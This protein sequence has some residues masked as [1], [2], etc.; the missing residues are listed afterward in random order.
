ME[1]ERFNPGKD[2]ILLFSTE[3]KEFSVY[4]S[5]E[6]SLPNRMAKN[7][8][9]FSEKHYGVFRKTLQWFLR[10]IMRSGKIEQGCLLKG[11]LD[12]IISIKRML[13]LQ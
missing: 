7:I 9:V 8:T 13:I 4:E 3:R 12:S 5:E 11:S 10:E 2:N 6:N 1:T